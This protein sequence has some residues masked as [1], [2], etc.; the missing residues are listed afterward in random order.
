LPRR[1]RGGL[2]YTKSEVNEIIDR[3][4]HPWLSKYPWLTFVDGL[5]HA[6]N[7]QNPEESLQKFLRY[8]APNALEEV[9]KWLRS[10]SR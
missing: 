2:P 9:A 10:L 3:L 8:N 5:L 7:E 6:L 1:S 4:L